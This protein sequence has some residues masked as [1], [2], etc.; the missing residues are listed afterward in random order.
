VEARG[1]RA[2]AIGLAR[3]DAVAP[4]TA[5]LIRRCSSVHTFGMRFALD[6]VF[7]DGRGEVVELRR[8]V[9]PR[10]VAARRAARAVVEARAGEGEAVVRALAAEA[11]LVPR[12]PR[13]GPDP[14]GAAI[15]SAG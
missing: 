6:L 9:A 2:R 8:G 7:L 14:P 15:S 11:A 5:L 1:L 12:R 13:R 3:L 4:G 10:R